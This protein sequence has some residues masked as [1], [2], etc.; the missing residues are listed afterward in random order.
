[1]ELTAAIEGLNAASPG[2]SVTM[3]GDSEYV[4]KGVTEWLPGWKARGWRTSQGKPVANLELWKA[5]EAGIAR[6]VNVRWE[7]VRGHD[8]H[9]LNERADGIASAEASR[10]GRSPAS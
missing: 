8:G 5:L 10:A 4:I 9:A 7:W 6:H 1:M 3:V 2:A